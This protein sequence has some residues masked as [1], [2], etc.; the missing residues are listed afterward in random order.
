MNRRMIAYTARTGADMTTGI[1][2]VITDQIRPR[3]SECAEQ[4][5]GYVTGSDLGPAPL[6]TLRYDIDGQTVT[7]K[8]AAAGVERIGTV[9]V[10]LADRKGN[11]ANIEVLDANGADA[12]FDFACF[13]G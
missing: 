10:R 9:V 13:R 5:P 4:I 6:Y 8:L 11:I 2:T 1:A 3:W 7:R 12:T